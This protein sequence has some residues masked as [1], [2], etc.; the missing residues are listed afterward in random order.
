M[1]VDTT[2]AWVCRP[3]HDGF[4]T[5]C[6]PETGGKPGT[7]HR[8]CGWACLTDADHDW[9]DTDDY[10]RLVCRHCGARGLRVPA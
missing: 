3:V 6:T 9:G 5:R 2:T 1:S 10:L 7:L 8:S 4:K